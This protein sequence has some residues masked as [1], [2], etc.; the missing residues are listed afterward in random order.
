MKSIVLKKDNFL[1]VPFFAFV[2][3]AFIIL[4]GKSFSTV[5]GNE[6]IDADAGTEQIK[7]GSAILRTAVS[8]TVVLILLI[9]AVYGIRWLQQRTRAGMSSQPLGIMG[10]LS[11]GPKKSIHLVRVMDRIILI[12]AADG[13]LSLLSELSKEE[14]DSLLKSNAKATTNFSSVLSNQLLQFKKKA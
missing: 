13:S 4:P 8:F 11:L 5:S 3:I 1:N 14:T 6:S 7:L 12:G 9:L 2:I 10:T